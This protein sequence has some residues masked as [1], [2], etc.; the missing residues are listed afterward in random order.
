MTNTTCPACA[1]PPARRRV[2]P[3]WLAVASALG[4]VLAPKCPM[5]LV[6]YFSLFGVGLGAASVV[7]TVLRPLAIA[8]ALLSLILFLRRLRRRPGRSITAGS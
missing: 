1:S 5:C 7:V 4:A 8:L 6:G 2:R 3:P